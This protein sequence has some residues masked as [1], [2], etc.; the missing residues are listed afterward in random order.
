MPLESRSRL[1][2]PTS[3]RAVVVVPTYNERENLP[4]LIAMLLRLDI[5]NLSVLVV[6]DNSPDGTGDVADAIA[7]DHPGMV[8]VLHRPGKSGLGR[9]YVAGITRAMGDGAE[10]V[11]HMDADL[12][13]PVSV[14]PVM[15]DVLSATD[16]AVVV[17]S[18]YVAGGSTAPDWPRYRKAQSV[19]A[20]LYVNA[21]L[22]LHV[23]DAT[24][25]FRAWRSS[26][27]SAIDLVAAQSNGYSFHVEL[28]YRTVERGLRIVE[29]PITFV[30]RVSGVS[31]MSVRVQ[32]ESALAPWKL[33]LD[34]PRATADAG[35]PQ[36]GADALEPRR[37]SAN[38]DTSAVEVT[39]S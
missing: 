16:A 36:R 23:K 18:R 31:K 26:T 3:P 11:I 24:S 2:H 33:L 10:I 35:K 22:R 20:N 32:L 25:G 6:D 13:H 39:D 34:R 29:V 1:P 37:V 30:E 7:A 38:G 12:S 28:M 5:P 17:G 14:I 8:N 27:L 4:V 19:M 15:L 21:M 9:A